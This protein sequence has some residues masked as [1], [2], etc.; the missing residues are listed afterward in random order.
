[1]ADESYEAG[2]R[3]GES[4]LTADIR[5][6]FDDAADTMDDLLGFFR[7]IT[8]DPELT[9]P[10]DVEPTWWEQEIARLRSM[11]AEKDAEISR[12]RLAEMRRMLAEGSA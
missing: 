6:Q 5:V 4:S 7:R 3:D 2:Y 12:L 9:W 1:M 10:Q 11:L 8:G